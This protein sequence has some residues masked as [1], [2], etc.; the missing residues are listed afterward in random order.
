MQIDTKGLQIIENFEGFG[1][2]P[3]GCPYIDQTGT[4]TIGIGTTFY[5]N[6]TKVTMNDPCITHD[7]AW[8]LLT[9]YLKNTCELITSLVKSEINQNQFDALCSLTYNIGDHG[10]TDSTVLKR[11]NANPNDPTI[12]DAF[13]M[14][15]KS[16][17]E[18]VPD[19]VRRRKEE[20][21]LYFS[22]VS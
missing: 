20:S 3:K 17:G 8:Q 7:R 10:F 21:D 15:T 14:W 22:P 1:G 13:E 16:K 11:V 2:K 9:N 5:E 19:L 4:P 6:G 12:R 18:V